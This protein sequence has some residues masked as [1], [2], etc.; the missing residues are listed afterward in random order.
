V[1]LVF[2]PKALSIQHYEKNFTDLARDTIS[3]GRT[4][5]LLVSQFP[6]TFNELK[7]RE[8][9]HAG[10]KWRYLRYTLIQLGLRIPG[11]TD[12]II[13]IVGLFEKY[14]SRY[15]ERLYALTMDYFFWLGAWSKIRAGK[16]GELLHRIK[17]CKWFP[18]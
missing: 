1:N 9:D 10:W 14:K 13:Y 7:L 16:D 8:Y 15:L 4:A 5:V 18:R 11:T 12:L 3:E 17:S 6:D 2:N